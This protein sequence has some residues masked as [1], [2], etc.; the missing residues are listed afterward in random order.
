MKKEKSCG[1]VVFNDKDEVLMV[2]HNKGHWG[3]PKGHVEDGETEMDT[4]IREVFEE[5]NIK[6]NIIDGFREIDTYSPK[7]NTIKDVVYFVGTP[8]NLDIKRQEAEVDEVKFMDVDMAISLLTKYPDTKN[9][10]KK[11]YEFYKGE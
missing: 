8:I 7:T 1:I 5:T 9:V 4:A 2:K 11:A 6:A 3:M 10:L